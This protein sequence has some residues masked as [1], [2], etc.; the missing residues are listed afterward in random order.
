MQIYAYEQR[1]C[2]FFHDFVIKVYIDVIELV[3]SLFDRVL[4]EFM[5][6]ILILYFWIACFCS[7]FVASIA[8]LSP[9]DSIYFY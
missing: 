2:K 3:S 5:I 1:K 9:L 4:V 7:V 8:L 6:M